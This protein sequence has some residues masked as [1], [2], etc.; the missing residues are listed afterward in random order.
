M[1][2]WHLLGRLPPSERDRVYTRLAELVPPPDGVTRSGILTGDRR[3]LDLWWD[4]LGLNSA[5]F[6]RRWEGA[7][8]LDAR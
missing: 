8:P 1:T 7:W 4:E 2:L 6:W 3:M 5:S